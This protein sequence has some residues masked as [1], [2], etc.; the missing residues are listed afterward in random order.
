MD[1]V[2]NMSLTKGENVLSEHTN[3]DSRNDANKTSTEVVLPQEQLRDWDFAQSNNHESPV[4]PHNRLVS[5]PDEHSATPDNAPDITSHVSPQNFP[6]EYRLPSNA[7]PSSAKPVTETANEG[8]HA[9]LSMRNHDLEPSTTVSSSSY[10]LSEHSPEEWTPNTI[11]SPIGVGVLAASDELA[12]PGLL[13][14]KVEADLLRKFSTEVGTWMDLSDLS[15]TFA[16]KVCRLAVKDPLLKAASIA[17]AAKQQFLIGKLQDGM[18]IARKNYNTA[19]SL[20]INRLGNLD[21]PF[22]DYGF[23]ATVICSCYEMLDAP[24]SDWQRHLDGVFSFGRVHRVNG[25]SGGIAQAGF[26]SIARQEVVCAIINRST[27]RLDPDFWAVDLDHIG[28]EGSEDLVN[29]QVLTILAKVVNFMACPE[30][31]SV[32]GKGYMDPVSEFEEDGQVFRTIWFARSV[33]ASSWQMFHLAQIFLL[34]TSPSQDCS[35]VLAFRKIE[36]K[37]LYHARQICGIAQTDLLWSVLMYPDLG[38]FRANHEFLAAGCCFSD[39]DERKAAVR[40]LED[41]EDELGWAAKY[42]A[43]DLQEA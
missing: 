27:L 34:T 35:C 28:Q 16:K 29:N 36:T 13:T 19:I 2:P 9:L 30:G 8:A 40:L 23:A 14:S 5:L 39:P 17:C 37:L 7:T 4:S 20:L 41:I 32:K 18:Q 26:W 21:Q 10:C 22:A 31:S 24:T 38:A 25:S 3:E 1:R 12:P 42:R 15:E 33:C 6:T 11:A 43:R